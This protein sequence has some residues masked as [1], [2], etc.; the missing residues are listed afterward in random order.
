MLKITSAVKTQGWV[1]LAD[2]FDLLI[3]K[4]GMPGHRVYALNASK[5]SRLSSRLDSEFMYKGNR[6]WKKG[7]T[8]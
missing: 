8:Q 2:R 4:A 7:K 5:T 1:A 6:M 3:Y